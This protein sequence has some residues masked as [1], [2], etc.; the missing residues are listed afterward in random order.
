MVRYML[1]VPR[2][3]DR[4]FIRDHGMRGAWPRMCQ[5]RP[6]PEA[7]I[8]GDA[9]VVKTEG[10][11]MAVNA[12]V[13]I[14]ALRQGDSFPDLPCRLT[15]NETRFEVYSLNS[16]DLLLELRAVA[17]LV[18]TVKVDAAGLEVTVTGHGCDET[19]TL[20]SDQATE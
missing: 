15:A 18:P 9:L 5:G 13:D 20:G 7:T 10:P 2:P 8:H 3:N 6:L 16:A 14:E 12:D 11:S 1:V 17:P 19:I 4:F